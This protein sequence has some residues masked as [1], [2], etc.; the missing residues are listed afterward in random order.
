VVF[1]NQIFQGNEIRDVDDSGL[2]AAAFT[3]KAIQD[4]RRVLEEFAEV[5]A[6]AGR[7]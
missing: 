2:Q 1:D 5:F 4:S 7:G 6:G 3:A